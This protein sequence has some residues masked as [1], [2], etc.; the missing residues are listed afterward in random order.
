MRYLPYL[1]FAAVAAVPL[2]WL[3]AKTIRFIFGGRELRTSMLQAAKMK[4][5]WI[6]VARMLG[7][8]I[9]DKSPHWPRLRRFLA[10][11]GQKEN[12][13]DMLKLPRPI[14]PRLR[15]RADRYGV[16]IRTNTV[17]K[18]GL[19]EWQAHT[20]HLADTWGCSRVAVT[21][22]KP[23]RLTVRAVRQDPLTVSTTHYPNGQPL[24]VLSHVDIGVDEYAREVPLR[25]SGVPGMGVYGLPGYG[26]TSLVNQVITKL[27][28]H[29]CVQI[30]V[31]DGKGDDTY[32]GADYE[33]LLPRF[34]FASGDS[35]E[36]A[37]EHFKELKRLRVRRAGSIR[38]VK[39]SKNIWTAGAD[40]NGQR[41]PGFTQ[42]WPFVL[43]VVDE[44]HTY[45][46]MVKDGGDRDLKRRNSLA[47][48]NIQLV[49]DLIKKGRSVGITVVLATQKGT[50]DAIPTAIRDVCPIS[51][52]FACR[53]TDAAVAALGDDIRDY[54][55]ANPV[56]LQDPAY[57]GV[58]T[59][60]VE[61][62]PGF[63]RVRT[64]FTDDL[65]TAN[66]CSEYADFTANPFNV[67]P[68]VQLTSADLAELDADDTDGTL[69]ATGTEG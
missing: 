49:Q 32:V 29:P 46:E 43:C 10:V 65:A 18:V 59:M 7:L 24:S 22:D 3:V 27:A 31:L 28:P 62:R 33:D 19:K 8:Y 40:A 38:R 68:H 4:I 56:T 58:M 51:M 48:E 63:T 26:K 53:T 14:F 44:S 11:L 2:T 47:S 20:Q 36:A 17:P 34:W 50:G 64:P 60:V 30:S 1:L 25:F 16:V 5:T 9:E 6:R 37:N 54:P 55:E 57:I 52:A 45:F 69:P 67:L 23:G 12:R 21:Q 61:G 13:P 66:V 41:I 42:D 15:V 39:G 35:L